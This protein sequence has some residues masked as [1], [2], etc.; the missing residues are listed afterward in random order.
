VLNL[1]ISE[2]ARGNQDRELFEWLSSS[3]W[4]VVGQLSGHIDRQLR[5]T[6]TWLKSMPELNSWLEGKGPRILWLTGLPGIGK[7][8]IAAHLIS[9]L[10]PAVM[11]GQNRSDVTQLT[12]AILPKSFQ[13]S[14]PL[15]LVYF[16]CSAGEDKLMH[17]HNIVQTFSYQLSRQSELFQ[18][19]LNNT[20]VSE[21]FTVS[22]SVGI[23][24]LYNRL[25]QRPL[26]SLGRTLAGD[27]KVFC[28][29]DGLDE[30]DF[31]IRD[32]RSAKSEIVILLHLLS[33]SSE[34]RLLILSR[35]I[36]EISDTLEI[37]P[38]VTREISCADNGDDI[39]FYVEWKIANSKKL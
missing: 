38:S 13:P 4:E 34:I 24:L 9:S 18:R 10:H 31:G 21:Q 36:K 30:A 19:E 7:S 20:R 3:H 29:I 37:L 32:H 22:P 23:R 14:P 17:A 8:I 16:F 35:R 26:S 25:I 39:E 28:I 11:D 27:I 6:L 33:A 15:Y 12:T 5:G 2:F 1:E